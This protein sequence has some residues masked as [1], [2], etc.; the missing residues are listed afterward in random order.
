VDGLANIP[1]GIF[2]PKTGML[3]KDSCDFWAYMEPACN[4]THC[5]I[6]PAQ[7]VDVP[8]MF[9]GLGLLV[10]QRWGKGSHLNIPTKITNALDFSSFTFRLDS[11]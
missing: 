3:Q 5:N 4:Q 9:Y 7:N 2:W 8:K 11:L 10:E 6:K 1:N